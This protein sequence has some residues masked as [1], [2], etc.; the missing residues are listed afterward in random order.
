MGDVPRGGV[1]PSPRQERKTALAP[2]TLPVAPPRWSPGYALAMAGAAMGS[3]L[4]FRILNRMQVRGLE[5]VPAEHENVL[6]CLNHNSV[7]DNFAFET[8]AYLPRVLW[9]PEYLPVS[10][11][12]RKF[13][14]GDS[15][16]RAI[17]D[18]V[19]HVVGHHFLRHLRAFPVD[20][21]QGDFDQVS[22]WA[23][24]LEHNILVIYPEGTRSRTGEIGPGK[25]GVGKLIHEAH[26]T[27]IPVHMEG[28]RQVMGVNQV[29]P[30]L[31]H[32]V[33]VTIGRPMDTAALLSEPLPD[34]FSGQ[35]AVFRRIAERI[36]QAVRDLAPPPS[37]P[38]LPH[39][40]A[41]V[42]RRR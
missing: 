39:P 3:V 34:D 12:D 27:V 41:R 19:M 6:Y 14:F 2:S 15:S 36:L 21:N 20:R 38:P 42:L 1:H 11:A 23:R 17:R 35:K 8:A 29:I 10:L 33:R 4:L 25:A 37:D 9:R 5:N 24:L 18:R 40:L 22:Q 31:F 32:T 28:M 30:G 13:F 16:S 7:L 26:P